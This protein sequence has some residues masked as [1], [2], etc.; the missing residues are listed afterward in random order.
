MESTNRICPSEPSTAS[1]PIDLTM[2]AFC[3]VEPPLRP[4]MDSGPAPKEDLLPYAWQDPRDAA[5][6]AITTPG[7]NYESDSFRIDEA[8]GKSPLTRTAS[9]S[10]W[11]DGTWSCTWIPSAPRFIGTACV[12]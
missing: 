11:M 12:T 2:D 3:P 1:E 5:H 6:V 4:R 7:G 9:A 8:M 10:C